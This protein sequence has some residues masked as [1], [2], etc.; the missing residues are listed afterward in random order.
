MSCFARVYGRLTPTEDAASA[1]GELACHLAL[2]TGS[3]QSDSPL[4]LALVK[5]RIDRLFTK[6][7]EI[8]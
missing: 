7:A 1:R 3:P 8:G 4:F 2:T 5:L 6:G